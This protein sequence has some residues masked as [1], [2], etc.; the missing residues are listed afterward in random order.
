MICQLLGIVQHSEKPYGFVLSEY[1]K[2]I[3]I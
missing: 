1:E 3:E 2:H